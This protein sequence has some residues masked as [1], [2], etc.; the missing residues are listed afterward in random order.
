MSKSASIVAEIQPVRR[1]QPRVDPQPILT[2]MRKDKAKCEA[3]IMHLWTH[4]TKVAQKEPD[5]P[6]EKYDTIHGG[7]KSVFDAYMQEDN[8]DL[9]VI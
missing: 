4:A 5:Y 3:E 6:W 9:L 1:I 7:K 2:K 8:D